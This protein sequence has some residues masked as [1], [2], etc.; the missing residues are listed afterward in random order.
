MGNG[1]E[2]TFGC[3]ADAENYQ[4]IVSASDNDPTF[5]Q[6][7]TELDVEEKQ[8]G[9]CLTSI[10][11]T[12]Y[13]ADASG[14]EAF[15]DLTLYVDRR[16]ADWDWKSFEAEIDT[17][18]VYSDTS[19]HPDK[20]GW[21]EAEDE[22][23]ERIELSW[24]DVRRSDTE[25]ERT[26]S[27]ND[28]CLVANN[29]VQIISHIAMAPSSSPS[30]LPSFAPSESPSSAPSELPSL[31]PSEAPSDS[32]PP[33]PQVGEDEF[34]FVGNNHHTGKEKTKSCEWLGKQGDIRRIKI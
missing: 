14:N 33:S 11:R 21:P 25:I 28:E 16:N 15:D 17:E 32:C 26:W 23:G 5:N 34:Y 31:E 13:A 8:V 30:A 19:L 2:K 20:I 18:V 27:V 24:K 9:D 6:S 29:R 7:F 4:V 3:K 10:R 12:W 1:G 22:C